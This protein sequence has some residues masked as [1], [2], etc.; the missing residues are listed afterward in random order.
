[1]TPTPPGVVLLGAASPPLV[2]P[3][4]GALVIWPRGALRVGNMHGNIAQLPRSTK[5][6]AP[7]TADNICE[8]G[9]HESW[10]SLC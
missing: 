1:V 5:R 7:Y 6:L 10:I 8:A 4:M 9:V 3:G 2:L